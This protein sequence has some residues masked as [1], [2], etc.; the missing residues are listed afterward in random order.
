MKTIC[1]CNYLRRLIL[2]I[3]LWGLNSTVQAQLG[4]YE[5]NGTAACPNTNIN[6]TT[7]PAHAVFSAFS[8]VNTS[9]ALSSTDFSNSAW[10]TGISI[11]VNEYNQFTITPD[12]GYALTLTSLSF[13][14]VADKTVTS[15]ILRS[16]LDNYASNIAT[17]A[18]LLAPQTETVSLPAGTFTNTGAVTFRLYLTGALN[19][20]AIWNV[21]NVSLAGSVVVLP[22]NPTNPTSNSPQCANPGVTLTASGAPP[23]GETWYWQTTASGTSTA[24]SS[25]TYI[26]TTSG[27]YFLRS[28]DNTTLAW[29]AGA[30]SIAITITPNVG[31]PVFSLGASSTRCQAAGTVTY[32]ATATN[33]T[34]I[35]YTLDATSLAGGNSID[36]STGAVTF[37]AGWNGTSIITATA[38]GCNGPVSANHTVTISQLVTVPVFNLGSSS[39]RCQGTTSQTVTYTAT[40]SNTTG[41]TYSLDATTNAFAGNSINA[42]TGAVTFSANWSG[43]STITA[44]AAGC[45]PQ[46][47]THTVTT[48]PTVGTPVFSLGSTS[49]R[50][51]AVGTVSYTAT[52][53][54]NTGIS[55]SLD[56]TSVSGGNS[57]NSST[58]DVSWDASWYGTS[59]ITVSATGCNGPKTATHTVTTNAPVATPVFSLGST[60]TR[61]QA[62]G[63]VNYTATASYSTGI[64]YSLDGTSLAGGNTIN[65]SN[66]T[67]SY[68]AGWNGTSLI[69]ATAA[70]CSGPQTAVHT[71][72]ITP[73]VTTPVF[74]SGSTSTR[75]Q[76]AGTVNYVATASNTTGITYSIDNA[77][78]TGGNSIN[79]STGDVSWAAGWSGTTTITASAAGCSGPRTATHTV[80]IT[81]TV[82]L[83]VFSLG[84]SSTRCQGAG[85]V[86]YT[87]TAT[88]NTGITYSL[89]ATST[90]AGNTI[91]TST[92]VV[93]YIAGW[94][95]TSTVTATATGCN[96]PRSSTH[97][98]T[99]SQLV[100]TPVFSLGSS[101]TRCQGTSTQTV[102]YTATANNTTG[103]T[104]SLDATTDAFAG[105]S[106]NASTGAVTFS[107]NWSGTSTITATAAG[108]TPQ[109]ATHT[110]TTTA[111]VGLPVFSLGTTSSR[112]QAAGTVTYAATA[113]TN[114]GI[115]YSLDAA[116]L[117]GGNT[118]N[119]ST[120]D[121]T[122]SASW[123]G[124]SVITAT[125]SGCNGPRSSTHTVTVNA[126]VSAPVFNLGATSTICQST[127]NVTYTAT[128]SN[129]TGI[130]YS[131]DAASISGGNTINA[132]GK[133]AY[134]NNWTGTS[135]ITASAAGCYGPQTAT[136]T[137]TITPFVT[138]P[139]FTAGS[140]STRCQG[141]STVGYTATANNAT[142]I[143]YSL[144]NASVNGGNTINS[145]TG[146]VTFA[147]GWTGSSTVTASAAGCNGPK[148]ATHTITTTATVGTPVFSLGA[149]TTR[150]Q[151]AGT[152]TYT[153]TA[154]TN[155]GI[156]YSLDATSITGGCTINAST[157]AVT[158]PA[159]WNGTTVITATA[160]GCNGPKTATHTVTVTPYVAAPVF[161]AGTTSTICQGAQTIAY[162]ATANYSTGISYSL[163]LTSRNNGCSINST[164][165]AVTYAAGWTGTSVITASATG[166]NGPQTST[167]TVTITPIVSTPV[168]SLGASS[169]RCQGAATITYSATSNNSTGITY[170]LDASS[171]SG[172]NSI[173]A[174]TGDVSWASGW[175]GTSTITASAAGCSGPKTATHTVT[176]TASV[177]TPVFAL[178]S[179]S[180]R[181]QGAQTKT[182][183]ATATG[184]TGIS[185]SLD[186]TSIAGGNTIV[187]A[188]GA[189]TFAAGWNGT[190]VITATATGCN[191]P[192]VATH[193]VT[194]NAITAVKQLYLA[195]VFKL[196]RIDPVATN[197]LTTTS[198]VK[199]N[200]GDSAIFTQSPALSSALTIK[201]GTIT[202]VNYVSGQSGT[203]PATANIPASL[204]YGTTTIITFATASYNSVAATLTWTGTLSSDVTIPSGQAIVFNVK[205]MTAGGFK[206]DYASKAK[207]SHIDLPVTTFINIGSLDIFDAPYPAGS[208][209]ISA[210]YNKQ[211]YARATVTDP[212][213][214][215]DITSLDIAIQPGNITGTATSVSSA[216]NTRIFEFPFTAAASGSNVAVIASAKEGY[217]NTVTNAL[218]APL[219]VCSSCP[220]VAVDD[221][222]SGAGGAPILID[223]LANDYDPNGNLNRAS[224]SLI[225]APKNGDAIISGGKFV[226]VPNG[227]FAGKDTFRYQVC[228]S[229][230]PAALCAQADVFITIDPTISDPCADATKSQIYY[231]PFGEAEARTALLA[232][233]NQS[234]VIDSLR[235]IISLKMPYPGMVLVWDQWEDGY[236]TDILNPTQSTTVVWGDANPYNGIAP[237][238]PDDV[239]PAGG[240]IV[241]DNTVPA[242]P[243][244]PTNIYYD[245]KDKIYASGQISVV[246]VVGEPNVIG[247]Q[248]MKINVSSTQDFGKSFTIPVGQNFPSQ[249]FAY[250]AAFIRAAHD[251]TIVD[252][253]KDN[254]G[255]FDESDTLSE[256][257]TLLVP[258]IYT[259]ASITSSMP[260]GVDLHFA[261][262][263]GYSSREVPVFPANWYSSTYYSPVPTT[264]ASTAIKDTN[265]VYLYNSLSRSITINWSSGVP[266][267]GSILIPAKSVKRFALPL[268][269]TAAYKFTNPTGESFTA[270]QVCDSYTPGG[271]GNTGTSYDWA[272]NLISE[273]RLT[274]FATLAWA[275]G[276]IDGTRNDNP[277]WVTPT[278]NTTI[279]VKYNGDLTNGGSI[280]PCGLHYDV[281]YSLNALNHKRVKDLT[282]NDQS[283]MAVYT[284]D[285]TRIAA[286]YG[287]DPSS[288]T[289]ANP[290]WDVGST[291]RPFCSLKLIFAND[292]YAFTA[293]DNPVTIPILSN[294]IGFAATVNPASVITSGLLQPKHGTVVINSNGTILYTPYP[295]YQG[296]DT[297]EYSVCSTPSPVVCDIA[298]VYITINSCPPPASRNIIYG[299]VFYDQAQNG[300]NNT[301]DPGFNTGKVLLYVDGNCNNIAEASELSDSLTVDS[302]GTYQFIKY[303]EKT[304]ADNFEGNSGSSS[305]S[306]GNTGN[307][308]WSG[309]W[310]DA[311]DPSTGF[312]VTPAQSIGNTHAEIV[313]DGAFSYAIRLKYKN[314]SVSRSVN[315]S[316]ATYA[317]LSFSYRKASATLTVGHDVYVQMS[318]NGGSSFN[319]IFT[320]Q[321]NGTVDAAYVNVYNQD[322]SA[323]A[324]GTTVLR[325][326]TSSGGGLADSVFID[327]ISI[328]YLRYPQC[329]IVKVPSSSVPLGYYMTT[330]NQSAVS[331]A[332][333]GNCT[334]PVDF[335]VAPMGVL[336]IG[337]L[338]FKGFVSGAD[339]ILNWTTEVE[340]NSDHYE[341]E[342]RNEAGNYVRIGSVKAKGSSVN[343]SIYSFVNRNAPVGTNFYRL[344]IY[345][346]DASFTYSNII[347]LK[348][349][350]TNA[351]VNKVYPNPFNDKV[352]GAIHLDN[353]AM[354]FIK[355]YDAGGRLVKNFSINGVKG[356]NMVSIDGLAKL[357]SGVYYLE[358]KHDLTVFREKLVKSE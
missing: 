239:I 40:A 83:P 153:A 92:G 191:G 176:V 327:N 314:V 211:L 79:A 356:L 161:N 113:T 249:D 115:V 305:C 17:G 132:S 344:K 209:V 323:Y 139:V 122:W 178:G 135:V 216:A 301:N 72:T 320:I 49:S 68:A 223:V 137:V 48:T 254:N 297:L 195:D 351:V 9:C 199:Y 339:D 93:T 329:Y 270:L 332:G 81:P 172:G 144:D 86:T 285:G 26:A 277:V 112:C 179:Y 88:N 22:A 265:A 94:N 310:V 182:F 165:G 282:D 180:V 145:S 337:V 248:C 219:N 286:V 308:S 56:A 146:S 3:L 158:Y 91:N 255:T 331:F 222:V 111:T 260:I 291:M 346:R 274:T 28:Q 317:F 357:S 42:S 280:S 319:T 246:Q 343:R 36:A 245:G 298:T 290:S 100:T 181:S 316:G 141:S 231:L 76:G 244:V 16:S 61:C 303:P 138:T 230:L 251:N 63:N 163:D 108:C 253:D 186:A 300:V 47:A 292:D 272:F 358:V 213:G 50:C 328:K 287:E 19:N 29:S 95:G 101:S 196:D 35:V 125:A 221:S 85:S 306:T 250:T 11:N 60:S 220:P 259:G 194:T 333:T 318:S 104:Y 324:S 330:A 8:T 353:P 226:F 174:S 261:G 197:D 283:G 44:T 117:S 288:A 21:D 210:V 13:T 284:C 264:G 114:T 37:V 228:D 235:D 340:I 347:A 322:I 204:K 167:H 278:A 134:D 148:T 121:V 133:V 229:T 62:N 38:S 156:S 25:S 33:N 234:L 352:M 98:V 207:P 18:V 289:A 355:L 24:N 107:A 87:A 58:G 208:K 45:T 268:S 266:S 65:A 46:S 4:I 140:S 143:T 43:T 321:G 110:V 69:T 212:F 279:Y 193:S 55:Y 202:I 350:G 203:I 335:G 262:V 54:N 192:S 258:G 185:Y 30:G 225:T 189:V 175:N 198:T 183:S 166:C 302:S 276:S 120:G 7:Q 342:A 256:G 89:D 315:L 73:L 119:A 10:N 170:S 215:A 325:F 257:H 14:H 82:G 243:R 334:S 242:N 218:N 263:D 75:C 345:D 105:N 1:T 5:F 227:T 269:A 32:S 27:T 118:I 152:V 128:A 184:S 188:T 126:P 232:S 267:S 70:G 299:K 206:I 64:T 106:I 164:T 31:T 136:H 99:T 293:T 233:Q 296:N 12:A 57:I 348:R 273:D 326:L 109:T 129:S 150:C 102:T 51:Q 90:A 96:G 23:A 312:C 124:T 131:L 74:T 295:G 173:N 77:S 214:A 307:T 294:D 52:A 200:N 338:N 252:I 349:N 80:T 149:T 147:A 59:V 247:L 205:N 169:T 157:G 190:S 240:G 271:G 168:F 2:V 151:G 238:Y 177:G 39:T 281:S 160:S 154:T 311:G 6:V 34:G 309:N 236:E 275:P 41:I 162:T 116:S 97:T 127:N 123:F 67:V 103:I 354:L 159:G 155:T 15:W 241:L 66:G 201:A 313:K 171:V 304:V 20:T 53:T 341:V 217:E 142:G 71:V 78:N 336:P 130:T 187:A 84:A 224:L 237:G